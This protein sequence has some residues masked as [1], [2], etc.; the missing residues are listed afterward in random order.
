[1]MGAPTLPDGMP[2]ALVDGV[3]RCVAQRPSNT[4][5]PPAPAS[6]R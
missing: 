3:T 4:T 6:R 2:Q 5:P 1:V